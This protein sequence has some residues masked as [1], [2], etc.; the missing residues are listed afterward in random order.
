MFFN[1]ILDASAQKGLELSF[2][3]E[4]GREVVRFPNCHECPVASGLGNLT[5]REVALL[6]QIS[7]ISH[8][9]EISVTSGRDSL[10]DALQ[11]K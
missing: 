8:N 4:A 9:N 5:R 6:H 3:L 2:I 7:D 11:E 10:Q 1:Y